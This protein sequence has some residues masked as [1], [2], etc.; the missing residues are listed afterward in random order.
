MI[1]AALGPSRGI[2]GRGRNPLFILEMR[3]CVRKAEGADPIAAPIHFAQF[4][5][6]CK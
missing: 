5:Q 6:A 4:A 2:R 1:G 3:I